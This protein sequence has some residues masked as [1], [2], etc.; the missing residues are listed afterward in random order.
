MFAPLTMHLGVKESDQLIGIFLSQELIIPTDRYSETQVLT[1][2]LPENDFFGTV[3][4]ICHIL[5]F[6]GQ[7]Q[8]LECA[9]T[10]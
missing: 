2:C 4:K 10:R 3:A 1:E 7:K 8:H 9:N 5:W 6:Q